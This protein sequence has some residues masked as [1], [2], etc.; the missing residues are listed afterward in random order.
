VVYLPGYGLVRVFRIVA[1]NGDTTHWATNDVAMTDLTR[2]Q[3][4]E[5]I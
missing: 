2:L 1:P 4:A 5:A 3:I